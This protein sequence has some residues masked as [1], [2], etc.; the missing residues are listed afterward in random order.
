MP[1]GHSS[2]HHQMHRAIADHRQRLER[3]RLRPAGSP[4]LQGQ[5]PR[6]RH[7]LRKTR[8]GSSQGRMV[9]P[10]TVF[11][12]GCSS[13]WLPRSAGS[14]RSTRARFDALCPVTEPPDCTTAMRLGFSIDGSAIGG[15]RRGGEPCGDVYQIQS[16]FCANPVRVSL[17]ARAWRFSPGQRT[18]RS[19]RVGARRCSARLVTGD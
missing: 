8:R 3:G 1:F 17:G 13:I 15:P 9:L 16:G 18:L 19:R 2:E 14:R 4:A 10:Q 7:S 6:Q 11:L 12:R 5:L